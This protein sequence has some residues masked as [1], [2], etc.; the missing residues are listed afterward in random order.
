MRF[1][2]AGFL[3]AGRLETLQLADSPVWFILLFPLLLIWQ[4]LHFYFVHRALHWKPLY[5]HV[6]SVHHRNV[7][8]GP[9]SGMAMHPVEHLGYFSTL[10]IFLVLPAHPVHMIFALNWQ[11][12]GAPSSHSGYEAVWVKDK[13]RLII[14]SFFH[15]LHHR[16]YECNYGGVE[17]P[18]DKWLGTY[19]DGS[20]EGTRLA[21]ER[22]RKHF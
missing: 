18:W 14:G 1:V 15:Q 9:W 7:N 13:S 22:K 19:H 8:P 10:L 4:S 6:H 11:F 5:K 20:E 17:M 21:R 3:P 12:L 2:S 16:Y